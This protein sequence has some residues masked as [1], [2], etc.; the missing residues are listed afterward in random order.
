MRDSPFQSVAQISEELAKSSAKPHKFALIMAL[1]RLYEEDPSRENRFHINSELLEK[2][3]AAMLR[4][5]PMV[6][7]TPSMIEAPFYHLQSNGCWRLHIKEGKESLVQDILENKHGRFTKQRLLDVYS[8]ASLSSEFDSVLRNR[9]SRD[10]LV[11]GFLTRFS[12]RSQS[13]RQVTMNDIKRD[14]SALDTQSFPM[15]KFWV[16]AA[17]K[18]TRSNSSIYSAADQLSVFRKTFLAGKNQRSAIRNW[19]M[20]SGIIEGA[21]KNIRLSDFGDSVRMNDPLADKALTWWLFHIHLCCNDAFP[22]SAL[23]T[24]FGIDENWMLLSDVVDSIRAE[25]RKIGVE[26]ADDTIETYFAGVDASFRPGQ[27]LYMLGLIERRKARVDGKEKLL[28]RRTSIRPSKELIVYAALLLH[29]RYFKGQ[30]TVATPDLLNCGLARILGMRDS[31][32][33]DQLKQMR[34]DKGCSALIEYT[35]RQDLDSVHFRKQGSA[36]LGDLREYCYNSGA[37][38]WK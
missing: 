27:M 26:L 21:G 23:F 30:D 25:A 10:E 16:V 17:L 1:A 37:V 18:E 32:L 7:Y 35:Q 24:A 12:T 3:R 22:Y 11:R 34:H 2:F 29:R 36:P 4:L 14:V 15:K 9:E 28:I 6:L 8:H 19:L 33:R 5:D 13:E 38:K 20:R 31:D